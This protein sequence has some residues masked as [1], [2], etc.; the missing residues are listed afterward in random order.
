MTRILIAALF[1][2]LVSP[3][4]ADWEYSEW[5]QTLD[6]LLAAGAGYGIE[7]VVNEEPATDLFGNL[8]ARAETTIHGAPGTAR[9]YF[10]DDRLANVQIELLDPNDYG[11]VR[12]A[13]IREHGEPFSL[14]LESGEE[15][16]TGDA[17]EWQ[18]TDESLIVGFTL[19]F[20]SKLYNAWIN[21]VSPDRADV[22]AAGFRA[23]R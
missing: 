21:H 15:A 19:R 22:V 3:A 5:N 20:R 8:L 23:A 14:P 12:A 13:L 11:D 18:L 2:T 17:D 16:D 9:F 1:A 6:E 10:I 7:Q 4:Q